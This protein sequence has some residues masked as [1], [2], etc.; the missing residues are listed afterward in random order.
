MRDERANTL[1]TYKLVYILQIRA[2]LFVKDWLPSR[3]LNE[4]GRPTIDKLQYLRKDPL[5]NLYLY[6]VTIG[7][8]IVY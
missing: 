2:R 5:K 1:H 7:N 4:D 8:E 3:G 6:M